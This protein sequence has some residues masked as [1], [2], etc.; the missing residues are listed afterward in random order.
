MVQPSRNRRGLSLDRGK[1]VQN[2]THLGDPLAPEDYLK[3][4]SALGFY[5]PI[6]PWGPLA[7]L[8]PIGSGAW[9][10]DAY[11]SGDSALGWS[12]WAERLAENGG[13]L[14]SDGPLGE[15]GPLGSYA[16]EALSALLVPACR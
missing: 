7:L 1:P 2:G 10:P 3:P 11:V 6:G 4:M 9:S 5:G 8:G 16:W 14:S 13:P 12:G 15:A